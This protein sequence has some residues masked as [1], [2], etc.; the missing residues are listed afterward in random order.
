MSPAGNR[1]EGVGGEKKQNENL[2][3]I[4]FFPN[5]LRKK[6]ESNFMLYFKRFYFF[7]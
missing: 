1:E 2:I 3:D 5:T 4:E 6:A 7:I